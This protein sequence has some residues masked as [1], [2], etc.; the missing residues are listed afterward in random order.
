MACGEDF[1]TCDICND[2]N[3]LW[4]KFC[5][6]CGLDYCN[7]CEMTHSANHEFATEAQGLQEVRESDV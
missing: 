1:M 4:S 3:P 6:I 7:N 5:T 2:S